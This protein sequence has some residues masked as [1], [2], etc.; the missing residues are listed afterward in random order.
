[1]D[2]LESLKADFIAE[3]EEYLSIMQSE[4]LRLEELDG[5]GN[6]YDELEEVYRTTHSLKGAARSVNLPLIEQL[7]I[8][9]EELWKRARNGDLTLE[10]KIFDVANETLDVLNQLLHDVR[11]NTV[12]ISVSGV[13]QMRKKIEKFFIDTS[14]HT[15]L[16]DTLNSE[17]FLNTS[18]KLLDIHD[19]ENDENSIIEIQNNETSTIKANITNKKGQNETTKEFIRLAFEKINNLL[20]ETEELVSFE[21]QLNFIQNEVNDLYTEGWKYFKNEVNPNIQHKT[22]ISEFLNRLNAVNRSLHQL[23][24]S[25]AIHT[26]TILEHSHEMIMFPIAQVFEIL[27]RMVRDISKSR[28]KKVKLTLI[29]NQVEIDKRIV[30]GLKDP[31]LHLVRN[32][33]D[34]GI[35]SPQT[36]KIQGKPEEGNITISA[37]INSEGRLVLD[38]EDDGSGINIHKI[39]EKSLQRNVV[40][41]EQIK[42]MSDE[43]IVHLIFTSG[44]STSE[45]IN[46]ISG[47]GLGMT[48]VAD[49]IEKLG[50]T[51]SIATQQSKGTKFTI[52]LPRVLSFFRGILVNEGEIWILIPVQFVTKVFSIPISK[53]KHISSSTY[54]DMEGVKIPLVKLSDVTRINRNSVLGLKDTTIQVIILQQSNKMIALHIQK[55]IGFEVGIIRSFDNFL[56]KHPL[57]SGAVVLSSGKLAF[58]VKV[59]AIFN[60]SFQTNSMDVSDVKK[61]ILVVDDSLTVRNILRNYLEASGFDVSTAENGILAL[62]KL[63]EVRFDAVITDIEMPAMNGLELIKRIRQEEK[64]KYLPVV[65]VST[66]DREIDQQK[67]FKAGAN[68]YITKGSFEKG[69]LLEI[70]NTLISK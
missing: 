40:S 65:I 15:G 64:W 18:D 22:Y 46:D 26:N 21:N 4:L 54:I 34:H 27:P 61:H 70:L 24:H 66:L 50:G 9:L 33:I 17:H 32:C 30:E 28:G 16:L 58:V 43:E 8:T 45:E 38:I 44:L 57:F 60:H 49:Q 56:L 25:F 41:S 48:I 55:I 69:K 1:M 12:T 20:I 59:D 67:G 14:K 13:E 37:S 3:A 6:W 62:S 53:I 5:S 39:R 7:C 2:F 31:L 23:K 29:D 11:N 19:K 52:L 51:I 47:H 10:R 68:A 42:K 63:R 35:E 36:R